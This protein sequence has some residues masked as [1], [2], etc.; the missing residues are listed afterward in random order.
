MSFDTTDLITALRDSNKN[1]SKHLEGLTDEQWSWKPYP[2]CKSV[3]ETLTHLLMGDLLLRYRLDGDPR[4]G[5]FENVYVEVE[6][7]YADFT[8]DQIVAEFESSHEEICDRLTALFAGKPLDEPFEVF[9][10]AQKAGR[11]LAG[12]ANERYY[13]TGQISFI[14]IASD[15]AWDYYAHIYNYKSE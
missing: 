5:D 9:G 4:V 14:R 10:G 6:A 13:H 8:R 7:H 3:R 11:F 2:E 12:L 15:P 1:L